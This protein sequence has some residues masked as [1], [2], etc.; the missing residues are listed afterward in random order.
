MKK[1]KTK[2]KPAKV[3]KKHEQLRTKNNKKIMIKELIKSF[4]NITSACLKTNIDRQTF[5]NWM[6]DDNKF[7]NKVDEVPE[8]T[9]DFFEAQLI[10]LAKE[11]NPQVVMFYLKTKGK[12]RDYVERQEIETH[13][14][15]DVTINIIKPNND[16][17][18]LEPIKKTTKSLPNSKR[19][20]NN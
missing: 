14:V 3:D 13:A 10:K 5:Y 4:G 12:K 17:N 19:Q 11:K 8:I 15:Q 1:T 20:K 9:L 7:K 18:K 6:E 16:N 2:K